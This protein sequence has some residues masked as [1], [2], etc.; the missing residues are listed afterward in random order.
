MPRPGKGRMSKSDKT[1]HIISEN[2]YA[3]AAKPDIAAPAIATLA[4]KPETR[5]ALLSSLLLAALALFAFPVNSPSPVGPV[6]TTAPATLAARNAT[7]SEITGTISKPRKVARKR[8][9]AK[10]SS[11]T[12]WYNKWFGPQPQRRVSSTAP[13]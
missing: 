11:T 13:H 6:A 4:K 2:I 7:K 12:T 8:H 9:R 5:V 3:G 10:P 1:P